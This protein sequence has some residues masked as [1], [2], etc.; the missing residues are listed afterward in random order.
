[1][2]LSI[3]LSKQL[4]F[5]YCCFSFIF[6]IPIISQLK[7]K[8]YMLK[9][10]FILF[11]I[12]PIVMAV[13]IEKNSE[14]KPIKPIE[15]KNTIK[16]EKTKKD[17]G[18]ESYTS[19]AL[20]LLKSSMKDSNSFQ[21]VEVLINTDKASCITYKADNSF[22]GKSVASAVVISMPNNKFGV[23]VEEANKNEFNKQWNKFCAHK[24]LKD[25]TWLYKKL[26]N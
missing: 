10:L 3:S 21:I 26:Y 17:D 2:V 24:K 11:I 4:G 15:T 20:E 1:M 12:I 5:L 9:K 13:I 8:E 7:V 16:T 25:D 23:A 6:M 22:K 19:Q 14:N 18:I